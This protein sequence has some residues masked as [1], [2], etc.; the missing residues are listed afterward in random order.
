MMM[1]RIAF[2]AAALALTA[3]SALA[4]ANPRGQAK[5]V[6]DGKSVAI[7]YGRPSLQGRDM[8]A[9]AA[10]GQPWRLGADAATTLTTQAD[11]AFGSTVVPKGEYVLSAT[12]VAPDQWQLN[13][14]N[15]EKATVADIP[16]ASSKLTKAVE[17]FTIDLTGEKNKGEFSMS[18]GDSALKASF[19]AK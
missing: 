8:L 19:S 13:V 2:A 15:K 17:M 3:S 7:D 5:V 6:L 16:L 10:V 14:K 12:K 18:W 4:Q 9:Q 1:T 11:L